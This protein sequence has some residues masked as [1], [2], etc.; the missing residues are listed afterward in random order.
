[1]T[2]LRIITCAAVAGSVAGTVN[3]D[4]EDCG[5]SGT[6]GHVESINPSAVNQG[7]QTLVQGS[8]RLDARVTDGDYNVNVKA[9]GVS[10]QKC[11]ADLCGTSKCALPAFTGHVDFRGL[12]CPQAP[13]LVTLDFDVTVSRAVPSSLAYLEIEITSEGS[14][15]KLLC[16]KIHTS[17]GASFNAD[18]ENNAPINF[19]VVSSGKLAQHKDHKLNTIVPPGNLPSYYLTKDS[20][21]IQ[22]FNKEGYKTG[23][24]EESLRDF[25]A[26]ESA[27]PRM[28]NQD[29]CSVCTPLFYTT[30]VLRFYV[31]YC[32]VDGT[33]IY[34]TFYANSDCQQPFTAEESIALYSR[35]GET[36]VARREED[37]HCEE[38]KAKPV[39]VARSPMWAKDVKWGQYYVLPPAQQDEVLV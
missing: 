17:P 32:S 3:L 35:T 37:F 8:G 13:G 28:E 29:Q 31:V 15:G 6:H 23:W 36:N 21:T 12:A 11:H 5:D 9:L 1:M 22:T 24:T 20:R 27:Q 18:P 10:M 2:A 30:T 26:C 25:H 16:A 38:P 33:K 4:I 7:H 39:V 34:T 19:G 14:A